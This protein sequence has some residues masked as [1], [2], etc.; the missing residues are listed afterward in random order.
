MLPRNAAAMARM[1]IDDFIGLQG[2]GVAQAS[3]AHLLFYS[4]PWEK[5]SRPIRSWDNLSQPHLTT[6]NDQTAD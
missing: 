1:R 3:T 5:I 6:H 4:K 2:M